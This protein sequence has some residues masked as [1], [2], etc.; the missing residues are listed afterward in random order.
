MN[1]GLIPVVFFEGEY[2]SRLEVI[3][4]IPEGKAVYHFEHVDIRKARDFLGGKVCFRGNVPVSLLHTGTPDDVAAYVRQLID[5]FGKEGG[6]IV[7]SGAIFDEVK[8]ENIR[9]MVEAVKS[10]GA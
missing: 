4:D 10:Y 2:S 8:F 6:L 3:S 5:I 1:E 7:D 9:A